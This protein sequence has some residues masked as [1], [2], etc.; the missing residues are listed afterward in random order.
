MDTCDLSDM[1]DRSTYK[2]KALYVA[3]MQALG[4]NYMSTLLY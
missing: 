1:Y 4:I 2:P 3:L